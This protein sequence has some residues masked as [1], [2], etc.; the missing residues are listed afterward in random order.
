MRSAWTRRSGAPVPTAARPDE[1]SLP[2]PKVAPGPIWTLAP[3]EVS[4]FFLRSRPASEDTRWD[5]KLD[6]ALREILLR[7]NE[8]VPS[9]IGGI[10]LDDP[11]AKSAGARTLA[12]PTSGFMVPIRGPVWAPA[13]GRTLA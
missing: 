13:F 3:G 9:E 11:R 7:A 10:L 5:V 6:A 4:R 1:R 2:N 8:F 12:S